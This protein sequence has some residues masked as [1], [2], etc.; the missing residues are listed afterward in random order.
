MLTLCLAVWLHAANSMLTATT[1]PV[2]VG[3]IGGLPSGQQTDFALGAALSGIIANALGFEQMTRTEEYQ[4][5]AFWLFAGFVPPALLGNL[6][7]WRFGRRIGAD[8]L[9]R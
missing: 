9:F 6:V 3:D 5:V 8:T 7:A 4:T 2:A 1:L